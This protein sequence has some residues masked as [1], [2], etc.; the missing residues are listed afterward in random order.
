[1]K[2]KTIARTVLLMEYGLYFHALLRHGFWAFLLAVFAVEKS[3]GHA[4][5]WSA[6]C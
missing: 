1:M 6:W 3:T 2:L 5:A 4:R